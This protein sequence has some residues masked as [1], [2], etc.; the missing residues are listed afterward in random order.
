MN[1][2]ITLWNKLRSNQLIVDIGVIIPET[3]HCLLYTIPG[4]MI[5]LP[6]T[7]EVD[8]I[9][10]YVPSHYLNG[11][12]L[13]KYNIKNDP[14][15]E[16]VLMYNDRPQTYESLIIFGMERMINKIVEISKSTPNGI[17]CRRRIF[18]T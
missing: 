14:V 3:P 17:G 4:F 10:L 13:E 5:K 6:R 2:A 11:Y 12:K 1:S 7:A 16:I 9:Q 8:Q 15:F 18:V